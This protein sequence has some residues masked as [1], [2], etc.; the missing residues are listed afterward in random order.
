MRPE[1]WKNPEL[2][3]EER[4]AEWAKNGGVASCVYRTPAMAYE[5][6]ADAR[7]LKRDTPEMDM[8]VEQKL[9]VGSKPGYLVFIPEEEE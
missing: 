8:T 1:G 4:Q 7:G 5:A 9:L 6:G 2:E 3:F